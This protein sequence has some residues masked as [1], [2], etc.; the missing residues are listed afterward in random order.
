MLSAKDEDLPSSQSYQTTRE[1]AAVAGVVADF[2]NT[3]PVVS[4]LRR[5]ENRDESV[6]F[7][8]GWEHLQ[9]LFRRLRDEEDLRYTQHQ[10]IFKDVGEIRDE[11]KKRLN[12]DVLKQDI[13]GIAKAGKD[14]SS[15]AIEKTAKE[16]LESGKDLSSKAANTK[17][18]K[19]AD[20]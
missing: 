8:V 14:L 20:G 13:A 12:K 2:S 11:A 6:P 18:A 17:L 10:H 7:S 4:L 9:P 1:Q 16:A 19:T 15:K 5:Q 3:N